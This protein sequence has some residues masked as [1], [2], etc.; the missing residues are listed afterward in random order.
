MPVVVMGSVEPVGIPREIPEFR[1]TQFENQRSM[2]LSQGII[3]LR[4]PEWKIG[5][6]PLACNVQLLAKRDC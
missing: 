4:S 6:A 5:L 1:G 2:R 3:Q